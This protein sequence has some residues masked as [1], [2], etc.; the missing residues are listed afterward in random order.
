[1]SRY[2]LEDRIIKSI[3]LSNISESESEGLYDW[4]FTANQ[5][6]WATSPLRLTTSSF[7]LQLN[8]CGYNPYVTC[9]LTRGWV[10]LIQLLLVIASAV[11]LR[12]E[13]HGTH[14]HIL[15]SPLSAA[16]KLRLTHSLEMFRLI[17][18]TD[19][20]PGR[21]QTILRWFRKSVDDFRTFERWVLIYPSRG[22]QAEWHALHSP[23][24]RG[25]MNP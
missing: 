8:T 16:F 17:L 13:S 25:N 4:L 12:S 19:Q 10:C 6:V 11:I 20:S 22:A 21:F 18:W 15:L 1:M 24:L 23:H 9:Y 14:D 7:I 5:F 3:P 2:L